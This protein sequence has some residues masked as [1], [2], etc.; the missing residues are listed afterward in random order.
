[1]HLSRNRKLR[2]YLALALLF[3]L[4]LTAC[5]REPRVAAQY[6]SR[7]IEERYGLGGASSERIGT[8]EGGMDA[9]IVPVTLS[10]GRTA[11]LVI[12]KRH[13]GGQRVFLRENGELY[14]VTLQNPGVS[15]EEFV[16][17]QPRIVE[18]RVVDQPRTYSR[19]VVTPK[20]KRS[21]Q[22]EILIVAGS[23]GAGAAIG[24]VAGGKKGAAVGALSGGIAGLIYDLATR[25]KK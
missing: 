22:K 24:A 10:D 15:R 9:T 23:S 17:S 2:E 19:S 16:R 13:T 7:T 12:P 5:E 4:V 21:L 8:E 3:S 1:M 25:N 11:Q 14:P 20:K 18:R 6:D